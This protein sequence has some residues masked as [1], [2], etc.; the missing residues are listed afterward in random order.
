MVYHTWYLR[1]YAFSQLNVAL[2]WLVLLFIIF[3]IVP[4][5]YELVKKVVTRKEAAVLVLLNAL[6]VLGYLAAMLYESYPKY[7]AGASVF[8]ALAHFFV[9]LAVT[10]LCP[11][12]RNLPPILVA[13]ALFCLAVAVP[14]YFD[15]Y[16]T[17]M[18]FGAKAAILS[19]IGLKYKNRTTRIFSYIILAL[20]SLWLI[21]QLPLH[22]AAFRIILNTPFISWLSIAVAFYIFHLTHRMAHAQEKAII[23]HPLLPEYF[24]LCSL[25]VLICAAE[26]EWLSHLGLN[27][28]IGFGRDYLAHMLRANLVVIAG[29]T[30]LAVAKPF[31]PSG[32]L[33][34]ELAR[35][36][37]AGGAALAS[38]ALVLFHRESFTIFFNT[39][40]LLASTMVASLFAAAAMLRYQQSQVGSDNKLRILM[41][42]LGIALLWVLLTEEIYLYWRMLAD[43]ADRPERCM[44]L[45]QMCISIMWALYATFM[46][47]VGLWRKINGLRLLS[48]ALYVV[49]LVK[50]FVFDVAARISTAYRIGGFIVLGLALIGVSFLYQF[51]RNK[52][53]FDNSKSSE[54]AASDS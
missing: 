45:G 52:G 38:F 15:M 27:L 19:I 6:V 1:H 20:A 47:A 13:I 26:L 16:A 22:D 48:L 44:F 2:S 12:D 8:I 36:L 33:C 37:G 17:V 43:E 39:D 34:K 11:Q 3:L 7:L 40:F 30:I 25:G 51:C 32:L 53:F 49:V 18:V 4:I 46:V 54:P 24:Y 29:S 5:L 42:L 41:G 50:V 21:A 31:S 23:N 35:F 10:R 28:Q 14:L 9:L